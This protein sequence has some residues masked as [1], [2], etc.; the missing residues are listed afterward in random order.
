MHVL[1]ED[2]QVIEIWLVGG[3]ENTYERFINDKAKHEKRYDYIK[4]KI[5]WG[6][7]KLPEP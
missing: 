4:D 5:K 2:R 3:V 7:G 1:H 6:E